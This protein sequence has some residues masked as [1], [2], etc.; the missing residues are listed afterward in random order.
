MT[1]QKI[2]NIIDKLKRKHLIFMFNLA[3]YTKQQVSK[4]NINL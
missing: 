1:T 2:R 4:D 3:T